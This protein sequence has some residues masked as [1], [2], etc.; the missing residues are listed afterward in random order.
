MHPAKP[1]VVPATTKKTALLALRQAARATRNGKVVTVRATI[2]L[3]GAAKLDVTAT[4]GGKRLVL[5]KN[6]RVGAFHARA[7]TTTIATH[8]EAGGR[9]AIELRLSSRD[10]PQG[11]R[12]PDRHPRSWRHRNGV[13]HHDD[14]PSLTPLRKEEGDFMSARRLI[15]GIVGTALAT[16]L[17]AILVGPSIAAAPAP[18]P[19]LAPLNTV[20]VPEPP[21]LADFVRDKQAAVVLGKALFWD[22]QIGSDGI[23]ACATCHFAAGADSRSQN[24]LN[25]G[26]LGGHASVRPSRVRTRACQRRTSRSTSWPIR[27]TRIRQSFRTRPQ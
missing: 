10:A 25:P 1:R 2:E 20:A 3:K 9:I 16:A 21:N 7:R 15:P 26:T 11:A 4:S 24:Q 27:P 18:H 22:M 8:V 14:R 17:L 13:D 12:V 19:V 6:S 5:L 23:Q